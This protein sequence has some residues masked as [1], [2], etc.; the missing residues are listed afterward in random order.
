MYYYNFY[1]LNT[2]SNIIYDKNEI[3]V[4]DFEV[5]SYIKLYEENYGSALEINKAIKDLVLIKTIKFLF[6]NNLNLWKY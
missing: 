6:I 1:F 3:S 2:F 4:T 5:N